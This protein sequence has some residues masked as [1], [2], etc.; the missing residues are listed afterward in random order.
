MLEDFTV[1]ETISS[2]STNS[3]FLVG[4]RTAV[5][6]RQLMGCSW[7]RVES[8]V[9]SRGLAGR[10]PAVGGWS[11][12]KLH[13]HPAVGPLT[14]SA[15]LPCLPPSTTLCRAILWA[16]PTRDPILSRSRSSPPPTSGSPFSSS[17]ISSGFLSPWGINIWG[18]FVRPARF[19]AGIPSSHSP[20]P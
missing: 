1:L 16:P 14:R 9:V 18:Q 12:S 15:S 8:E 10:R 5:E 3:R 6:M 2:P 13:G 4:Y 20:Q 7:Q 19:F 17:L 11:R